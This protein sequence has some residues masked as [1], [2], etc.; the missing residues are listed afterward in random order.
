VPT[1]GKVSVNFGPLSYSFICLSVFRERRRTEVPNFNLS[2]AV[3]WPHPVDDSEDNEV[4]ADI[5]TLMVRG[6]GFEPLTSCA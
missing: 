6:R 1:K 5:L 2:K 3:E 4:D